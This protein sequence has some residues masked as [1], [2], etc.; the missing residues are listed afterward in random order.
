MEAVAA[1]MLTFLQRAANQT[2]FVADVNSTGQVKL[3]DT[4]H[5]IEQWSL[6]RWEAAWPHKGLATN[7]EADTDTSSA[8]DLKAEHAYFPHGAHKVLPGF[9]L[10]Y[11]KWPSADWYIMMDDDTFIFRRALMRL[12][13]RLDPEEKYY[14]GRH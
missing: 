5:A 3:A 13:S 2:G 11:A 6:A 8:D 1:L 4:G 12:L 14:I 10:M 9:K 7:S